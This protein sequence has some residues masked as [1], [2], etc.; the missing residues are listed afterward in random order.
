MPRQG[1]VLG[2]NARSKGVFHGIAWAL[3]YV[4]EEESLVMWRLG[5]SQLSLKRCVP[6]VI[7]LSASHKYTAQ[8]RAETA[9][10]IQEC[11]KFAELMG[12]EPSKFITMHIADLIQNKLIELFNMAPLPESMAQKLDAENIDIQINGHS[13]ALH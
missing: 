9:W 11:A 4:N 10:L 12:F 5:A 13:L 1:I 6:V 2:E 8:T 7:G 3:Q